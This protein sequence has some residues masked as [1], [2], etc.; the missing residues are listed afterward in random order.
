MKEWLVPPAN[1]TA[2]SKNDLRVGGRYH[3]EMI[4]GGAMEESLTPCAEDPNFK[5]G[6]VLLHEGEYLEITPP[7][8]LVFTWS[9]PAVKN[10]RVTVELRDLGDSTELWL[11]HELLETEHQRKSHSGGWEAA[12]VKLEKLLAT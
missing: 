2:R 7:E 9:S 4:V 3:H 1:W 8:K 12:L 6:D 11:T 5:P 10:T